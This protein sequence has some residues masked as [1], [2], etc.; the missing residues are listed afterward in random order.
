M[1]FSCH[2]GTLIHDGADNAPHKAHFI[3]DQLYEA[4][5]TQIEAGQ[6]SWLILSKSKRL[7]YQCRN[8]ARLWLDDHA[9]KLVCFTPEPGV[10]FGILRGEAEGR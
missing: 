5:M 7:M 3:P 10:E 8:C 1:K 6:S 4:A 9:G 2:C